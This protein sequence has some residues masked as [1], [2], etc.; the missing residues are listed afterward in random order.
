MAQFRT[1]PVPEAAGLKDV[2]TLHDILKALAENSEILTG[3]RGPGRA[4]TNDTIPIEP[5]DKWVKMTQI[6]TPSGYVTSAAGGVPT[7]SDFINLANDVQ[8]LSAD[9]VVLQSVLNLLLT[10]MR[11]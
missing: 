5:N 10:K 7:Y 6:R 2:G 3:Q 4:V 9:V 11:A 8:Q 1:T